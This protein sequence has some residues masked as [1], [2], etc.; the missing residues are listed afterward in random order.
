MR[1][2]IHFRANANFDCMVEMIVTNN[3]NIVAQPVFE[4]KWVNYVWDNTAATALNI[5]IS[6][7]AP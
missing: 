4:S 5:T 3:D 1:L 2:A 6:T 7:V